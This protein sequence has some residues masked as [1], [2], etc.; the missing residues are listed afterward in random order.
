MEPRLALRALGQVLDHDESHVVVAD[1]DWQRFAPTFTLA[2]RRPLLDELAEVRAILDGAGS[3]AAQTG[4]APIL[5]ALAGRSAGE[6]TRVLLDLVRGQVAAL[7]EYEDAAE[8]EPHRSFQDLG[9]DSVAAVELRTRLNTATGLRLP[10]TVV[11][12]QANPTAL[13]EHLG[14][15]LGGG[16]ETSGAAAVVAA[17]DRL[18]EAVAALAAEDVERNRITARLQSL[19]TRVNELLGTPE[20]TAVGERLGGASADDLFDF[21]DKELGLA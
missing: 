7:L 18:D 6:R 21:I 14:T 3:D 11:Y 12:D 15:L 17:L 4:E 8:V 19:V 5:A 16:T 10:A 20:D 1:F 9:F 2:R 13:A